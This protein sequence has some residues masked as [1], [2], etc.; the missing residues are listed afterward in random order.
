MNKKLIF[1][2][3]IVVILLGFYLYFQNNVLQVSSYNIV[4]S[5]IPKV[6]NDYKIIQ[7][8]D[9]HN[10]D[11]KILN[12][13]LVE[14]VK[15][16]H[17]NIIVITGDLVDS[18]NTNLDVAIEFVKNI[19][20]TAPI[21]YVSGNHEA[22]IDEYQLLK[23]MLEKEHVIIL[24]NKVEVLEVDDSKI[25]I[26]GVDDPNMSYHP[27]ATDADKVSS[28]LITINYDKT[29]FTILLAHRPELL[30]IYVNNHIDLVLTGHTHGG[31]VRIPFIGGLVVPNQGLFPK[32]DSGKFQ[33]DKTT[34][35]VSRGV[36][37]SIIPFRI[38]NRP[39][40]VEIVL[41]NK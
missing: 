31:Q 27:T 28:E 11:L 36:G 38:N 6:F 18:R 41:N 40:L 29:N 5:R 8:S 35:I 15:D 30:D 32:Y 9:F 33:D 19:K 14:E 12:S 34:M 7:I 1:I 20:G 17:P 24:D 22:N 37:N 21:Y 10:N 39:E 25:N 13:D 4:D 23:E 26:I 3:L 16:R 2:T